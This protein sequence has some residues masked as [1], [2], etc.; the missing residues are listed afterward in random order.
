MRNKGFGTELVSKII[1]KAKA[2]RNDHV[3]LQVLQNNFAAI[4]IY[5]KTRI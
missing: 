5:E 1:N 4:K 2:A 3:I